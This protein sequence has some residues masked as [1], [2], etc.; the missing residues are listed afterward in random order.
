M[1][2]GLTLAFAHQDHFKEI[3][4]GYPSRFVR[5]SD[6]SV[7]HVAAVSQTIGQ[8]MGLSHTDGF[9]MMR[10]G[11]KYTLMKASFRNKREIRLNGP[12]EVIFFRIYATS[13]AVD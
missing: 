9:S 3:E 5:E 8:S 2:Y 11:R 1:Y 13:F 10:G 6:I 7:I 12:R 4:Q